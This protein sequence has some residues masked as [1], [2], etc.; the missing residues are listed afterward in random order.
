MDL[1]IN[2]K[3]ALVLGASQGLG[4][5]IAATLAREGAK[6]IAAARKKDA[7]A[8][9]AQKGGLDITA[10]HV[11]LSDPASV[12]GLISMILEQGGVDILVN[13]AG[14]PM[15]GGAT[16]PDRESWNKTFNTM[17][18]SLFEI[19]T[20]LLPNMQEKKWGRILTIGS[21]GIVQPIP[22]LALS[23]TVRA[24]ITAWSRTLADEVAGDGITVNMILP[25]RIHTGRVDQLDD[26][27]AKRLNTT[28]EQVVKNSLAKIPAGRYGDPQ[29]FADVAAFLVSDRASYVTGSMIRVD[30][31]LI[32]GL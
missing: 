26:A 11:D 32:K 13:N 15:P 22:N 5:A 1:G 7:I 3:K 29:E 25:G 14:G 18:S 23:N 31:G 19:T 12:E 24:A 8:D 4:Q 2:G 9:W 16:T 20:R 28:R 17:A 6:V 10:K 21:S 30:G 27:A